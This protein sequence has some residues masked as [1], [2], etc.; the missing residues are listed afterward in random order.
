MGFTTI[1][2]VPGLALA[3]GAGLWLRRRKR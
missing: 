3:A 2:V 1:G